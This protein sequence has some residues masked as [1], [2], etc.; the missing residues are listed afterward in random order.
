MVYSTVKVKSDRYV[1]R[2]TLKH[3]TSTTDE[4]VRTRAQSDNSD[5]EDDCFD[6]NSD[7]DSTTVGTSNN[8]KKKKSSGISRLCNII[9][10][11]ADDKDSNSYCYYM[12]Y[13]YFSRRMDG[14]H[15]RSLLSSM[16]A[17]VLPRRCSYS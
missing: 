5:S 9:D 4:M 3:Q 15:E 17:Q 11:F 2:R 1:S 12:Y 16:E 6:D 13:W 10:R 14:F 7:G 8:K